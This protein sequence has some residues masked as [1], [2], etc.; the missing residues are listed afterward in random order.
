MEAEALHP[1]MYRYKRIVD[2]KLYIDAH[3]AEKIDL[4]VISDQGNFSKFHF[5]RLFKDAFGKTP[6]AYLT[7]VRIHKASELLASEVPVKE[8]CYAVG[9]DSVPS[10]V[11]LF[12]KRIGITPS[13]Y[14]RQ[15]KQQKAAEQSR[16]MAHVPHC[17]AN[18]FGR[19][20]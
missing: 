1:N 14:V 10:F 2:A 13:A 9:F 12:K 8:V 15:R 17:F 7:E 11:A 3:Y 6:N 4:S 20:K 5:L 16:P 19:V 18:S